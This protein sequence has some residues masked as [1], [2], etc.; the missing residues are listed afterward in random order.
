MSHYTVRTRT[1]YFSVTDEKK[2]RAIIS[3]CDATDEIEIFDERQADGSIKYGF[4][5]AGRINGLPD[6]E[7]ATDEDGEPNDDIDCN[8]D[9]FCEALQEILPE[10]DA[11]FITEVGFEGMR[12]LVGDCSIITRDA[13]KV[14]TL[15]NKAMETARKM[16]NN[17]EYETKMDY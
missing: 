14:I 9:A 5:C 11:I 4:L 17:P 10:N 1:N 13:Y 16:L 15:K 6:T 8:Y 7:N 12:C 2:F 3:S